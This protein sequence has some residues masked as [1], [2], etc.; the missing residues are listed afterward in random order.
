MATT[1]TNVGKKFPTGSKVFEKRN[2]DK[3]FQPDVLESLETCFQK[4]YRVTNR[5]RSFSRVSEE[6]GIEARKFGLALSNEDISFY[7]SNF[8]FQYF[9]LV[10]VEEED[11]DAMTFVPP[12]GFVKKKVFVIFFFTCFQKKN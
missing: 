3:I 7:L 9:K 2:F 1:Y 12:K 4:S 8:K 5:V 11:M 6:I 10:N